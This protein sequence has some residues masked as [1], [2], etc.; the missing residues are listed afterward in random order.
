M[1]ADRIEAYAES[2]L[3]LVRAEDELDEVTDELFRFARAIEASDELW[4]TLGDANVPAATR[5]QIVQDL[6]EG[7][8]TGLTV[9]V[10]G[11]LVGAGRARDIPAIVDLVVERAAQE[12]KKEVAEVRSAVDL[13]DE[14]RQRLAVALGQAT[15]KDIE[16]KVVVD[17]TVM[18]GVVATIGDTVIDGSVR[19]RLDQ[20]RDAF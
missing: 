18:G 1:D 8:A 15:G 17:P 10:V 20:L 14:Q 11:L 5:Q 7:K 4:R 19:H 12:R 9:A 2:V 13:T 3:G 16:V 6:L